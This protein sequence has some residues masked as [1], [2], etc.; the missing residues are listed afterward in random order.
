MKG[1]WNRLMGGGYRNTAFIGQP[2]S[3]YT[4]TDEAKGFYCGQ[5]GDVVLID[6]QGTQTKF[7]S[8]RAGVIYPIGFV[9]IKAASSGTT[10]SG[11]VA[12]F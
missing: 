8:C 12:L 10:A 7:T 11:L 6:P 2:N 5:D 4:P 1:S 9:T 3:D